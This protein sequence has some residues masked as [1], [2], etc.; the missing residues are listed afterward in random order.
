MVKL[1]CI[2]A[3]YEGARSMAV[4][5]LKCPSV[6]VAVVDANP[7]LI[8]AWNSDH[9]PIF[10]PAL[11]AFVRLCRNRNLHFS[12]DV[13]RHVSEA[14][15]VFLSLTTPTKTSGLGAGHAS[16][17]SSFETA[18]R[19][20]SRVS[21]SHKIV[22]ERSTVPVKTASA[23]EIILS[24]DGGSFDVVSNPEFIPEGSAMADLLTPARVLIGG[25]DTARGRAAVQA[26]KNL[27]LNWV[28]AEKII[29]TDLFSAELAKIASN[30]F[31]AQRVSSINAMA[32]LCEATGADAGQ[33]AAAVGLGDRAGV[34][35][36]G[37]C[38]KK[39]LLGLVYLC[40][41]H[42]LREAAEYWRQVIAMNEH[43]KS[44]FVRRVVSALFNTVEGKRVAV[45]GFAFKKDT[46]EARGSP[47]ASVCEGLVAEGAAVAVYD[48]LVAEEQI[49][50]EV[51]GVE[52]KEDAYEAA[53][54]AHAV[55]VLTEWDE[56]R[57]LDY[58]RIFEG[59]MKPAF[60]F[61]GRNVV[62]AEELGRIGFVVY[63][64]GK[65]LHPWFR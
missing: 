28:P 33:V 38:L 61:D 1:C 25:R 41:R 24:Q 58:R 17:L 21:S 44:R 19:L 47:A 6:D 40:E 49:L 12:C 59:M 64:V 23:I 56:F 63:V 51:A 34:G 4:I 9:L 54:G 29:T 10:S 65:P 39:D 16:D 45:L 50:A 7:A 31:L 11:A 32:A 60:V 43:Q 5:A 26:L 2:G 30:A 8:S 35:F 36:G 48:P 14:D 13:S 27:Y 55:C 3:G 18:V 15:I 20:I 22:V 62:D 53:R 52:V 37:P 46:D 42:G 57:G